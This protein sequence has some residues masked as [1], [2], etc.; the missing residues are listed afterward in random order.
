MTKDEDLLV[1]KL[2]PYH[3]ILFS[4]LLCSVL[5]INS[6]NINEKRAQIKLSKE[7]TQAY[8]EIMALRR[9]EGESNSDKVCKKGSD[10]LVKY[11]QTG[12]L[13]LID[14]EEGAIKCEDKDASYMKALRGL[15]RSLLGDSDS[16]SESGDNDGSGLRNLDE[17]DSTKD[18]LMQYL[19]RILPMAV[20]LAISI[21]SI[22][23]WI[24]C[25]I[26]NCCD[27][28]C[29]CCC[30]KRKCKI[31]CFIVAYV[32]YALVVAISI[33]GLAESNKIFEG[34]ANTECS[35]LKFLEQVV[36]GEI[37][38]TS[39]R[40][41][42]ID[43]IN[44]ILSRLIN[45]FNS[46][47][48]G[49]SGHLNDL[50]DDIEEPRTNFLGAMKSIGN[51]FYDTAT[52]D[53]K[54]SFLTTGDYT[55]YGLKIL[56]NPEKDIK[57]YYTVDLVN[58]FGQC[59]EI[60]GTTSLTCTP[61][62]S[63]LYAWNEEYST[64]ASD[65]DEYMGIA[66]RSFNSVFGSLDPLTTSLQNA[67]RTLNDFSGPFDDINSEIGGTLSDYSDKIDDYGKL[68]VKIVFSFLLVMNIALAVLMTLIGLFSMKACVDCCFCRCLFKSCVHI[69]WNVLALMMILS[70]LVGSIL[71]LVGRIGGDVMSLASYIF[72]QDNLNAPNPL[73]VG[74]MGDEGL[75]YLRRCMILDGDIAAELNIDG[76][77]SSLDDISRIEANITR[78]YNRFSTIK[79]NYP[80]YIY[81]KDQ[82][83]ARKKLSTDFY[84]YSTT[85][86]VSSFGFD[87]LVDSF[88]KKIQSLHTSPDKWSR[89][90]T[91]NECNTAE[92]PA[93]K[94]NLDLRQCDPETKY[95]NL[96]DAVENYAH[97]IT[98]I[99]S[100]LTSLNG[101]NVPN[102]P[103]TFI[104]V[105]DQLKGKYEPYLTSYIT[106]LEYMKEKIGEIMDQVREFTIPGKAFSFLNGHF[107][108][109]NLKILL[110]YLKNS[111]GKDLYT[112]GVCL[113]VVG[114]SLILSISITILLIVIINIGLKEDM[115]MK[116][117][118][119]TQSP[120]IAVSNYQVNTPD[121]KPIPQY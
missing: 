92:N 115:A 99:K 110:K 6:N 112:V 34:I 29:C 49:T 83:D 44:T 78:V 101:N 75:N 65:A 116:N 121:M 52:S 90:G 107:I 46:L 66:K 8:E 120:G 43:G 73:F 18:N 55:A 67:N 54:T 42:G 81:Y 23:G 4:C 76:Q 104:D 31:P 39:P 9:L 64:I 3:I 97:F 87:E 74:E 111:L 88:N 60:T 12:D 41:A 47:G 62:I 102:N 32:F 94:T 68:V 37:K 93:G 13:S 114:C 17:G 108:Q 25:C 95:Q 21:L 69:L 61:V 50:I 2:K 98:D 1:S 103:T 33:Y 77:V 105:L 20:F 56:S 96:N 59:N 79:S 26:C 40:W 58:N 24:G 38:Q 7:K 16:S 51:S 14:L 5:I 63:V 19:D 10:D 22:F 15:A 100:L 45:K 118:V 84:L 28:C 109:T 35:M 30:K 80:T 91:N 86:G 11:Y 57:G 119:M 53:Y 117:N 27:C 70:F 113:I 71:A 36:H 82:M 89:T 72:S 106:V 48:S 85:S